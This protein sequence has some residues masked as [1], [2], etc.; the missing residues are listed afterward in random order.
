VSNRI[1]FDLLDRRLASAYRKP[2]SGVKEGAECKDAHRAAIA[3]PL[4]REA[5]AGERGID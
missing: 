1:V 5:G 2:V 4:T 3:A